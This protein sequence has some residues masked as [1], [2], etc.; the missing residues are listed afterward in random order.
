MKT[1]R[2]L[3]SLLM[4]VLSS[5]VAMGHSAEAA[6][7]PAPLDESEPAIRLLSP[8]VAARFLYDMWNN[9][10]PMSRSDVEKLPAGLEMELLDTISEPL[11][12]PEPGE[13]Q[14]MLTVIGGMNCEMSRSMVAD[15]SGDECEQ[16][17]FGSRHPGAYNVLIMNI[18]T[19]DNET[20]YLGG[21]R[22]SSVRIAFSSIDRRN[23]T[24]EALLKLTGFEKMKDEDGAY[25]GLD[26]D[27]E[28]DYG[29]VIAVSD[30]EDDGLYWV[31]FCSF[32]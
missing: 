18:F 27:G 32:L 26:E 28:P 16:V 23:L 10:A 31:E 17:D 12:D 14:S 21:C 22:E 29:S 15:D 1:L 3:L 30:D 9:V 7:V 8:D 5:V 6:G 25:S 20:Y 24:L 19:W 4:P 2:L 13:P 11:L